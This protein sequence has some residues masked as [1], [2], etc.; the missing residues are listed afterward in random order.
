M[1]KVVKKI[2][3]IVLLAVD[4]A[5]LLIPWWR[6]TGFISFIINGMD[7]IKGSV[8]RTI[9]IFATYIVSV[10][11]LE[12]KPKVFFATGLGALSMYLAV[13]FY[14]WGFS[15]SKMPGAYIEMLAVIG[16]MVAFILMAFPVIQNKLQ[17]KA[18]KKKV[19][20]AISLGLAVAVAAGT[21]SVVSA[22]EK[23]MEKKAE[24]ANKVES[25]TA[26]ARPEEP[27]TEN[28]T[29]DKAEK[30]TEEP[31]E[32][33]T[34]KQ[35]ENNKSESQKAILEE[36][37]VLYENALEWL[38]F[39]NRG[40]EAFEA[41][42]NEYEEY[43][44]ESLLTKELKQRQ[45]EDRDDVLESKSFPVFTEAE[46][47]YENGLS[48]VYVPEITASYE[49]KYGTY[50]EML[51]S[52][53]EDGT[54]RFAWSNNGKFYA[55]PYSWLENSISRDEM[56]LSE[57]EKD[58][59][60]NI[61]IFSVNAGKN[62]INFYDNTYSC[63]Y[64]CLFNNKGQIEN[65]RVADENKRC[66]KAYYDFLKKNVEKEY[67][68][69]FRDFNGDGIEELMVLSVEDNPGY[70]I[71]FYEY[72][73][74]EVV[75]CFDDDTYNY[76][77]IGE[78]TQNGFLGLHG[79]TMSKYLVIDES[80]YTY[81]DATLWV[82]G[83][84]S[85]E[86][87]DNDEL[88]YYC[89]GKVDFETYID[90]VKALLEDNRIKETVYGRSIHSLDE[91]YLELYADT[92][93]L[94]EELQ[95]ESEEA[96]KN[97]INAYKTF[98]EDNEFE[99]LIAQPVKETMG[100]YENGGEIKGFFLFD[101]DKDA[102]PELLVQKIYNNFSGTFVYKYNENTK[103]VERCD[104][105]IE[106]EA[107]GMLLNDYADEYKKCGG[108]GLLLYK[109]YPALGYRKDNGNIITFSWN[110][111]SQ[112]SG[113][114]LNEYDKNMKRIG[115]YSESFY[116][117][118]VSN[119]DYKRLQQG[120]KEDYEAIMENYYPFMF[121]EINEGNIE[122]Y[123]V[124]DYMSSGMYSYTLEKC[125]SAYEYESKTEQET[126]EKPTE[127][128][129]QSKN[130]IPNGCS[131]YVAATKTTLGAGA[132]FPDKPASGDTY[133]SS[134]YTYTYNGWRGYGEQWTEWSVEVRDTGKT[135]YE[136]ILSSIAD[137]PVTSMY[138]T[139]FKCTRMTVAPTI[140]DSVK[141]MEMTFYFCESLTEAPSIPDSVV[142]M[143]YTFAHCTGLK[144]VIAISANVINMEGTF[145]ACSGL[146]Q[147]PEL[148]T[149]VTNMTGT[150][151]NCT[152]LKQAP[153]IPT[154]VKSLEQTFEN[155]TNLTGKVIINANP[156]YYSNCFACVDMD[157]QNITLSGKSTILKE[158]KATAK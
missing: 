49:I 39:A 90:R 18:P 56:I 94:K 119:K 116:E 125:D 117:G 146:I 5:C 59:F 152:K 104:M 69:A 78:I 137:C 95:E 122:K 87:G 65:I 27:A 120:N 32:K 53:P 66:Y 16:T 36:D 19:A 132:E 47:S 30:T 121:V 48:K 113:M 136:D 134:D 115:G 11:L 40:S 102:E 98:I 138:R 129:T 3:L 151:V 25:A 12:K 123:I 44:S 126:T 128:V 35:T 110:G 62:I 34:E 109:H 79:G 141:H 45:E 38:F 17:E 112:E 142:N 75:K 57:K 157:K 99:E 68:V 4:V 97:W 150:F 147:I 55:A 50:E 77:D 72:I 111:G 14:E 143:K 127:E 23:G 71:R 26:V 6:Y 145:A 80:F 9:V 82:L 33:Q 63:F 52:M 20:V 28:A 46:Y 93:G 92:H 96:G 51:E 154:G 105:Y 101:M 158:L 60:H 64:E 54:A 37:Y 133:T 42:M 156:E 140:P 114:T 13:V 148:P 31:T 84:M 118:E 73:D 43:F 108:N 135:K 144:Q 153:Q 70:V 91:E 155:C 103:T 8:V 21:S 24:Q 41:E 88:E 76:M 67:S 22:V 124:E 86:Y 61:S 83:G 81:A 7:V 131:Y 74:G 149:T 1:N 130:L 85:V 15:F 2:I 10:I 29:V 58:G 139:F 107:E 100:V 89:D 106:N